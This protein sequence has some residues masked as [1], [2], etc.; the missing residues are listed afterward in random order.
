[1]DDLARPTDPTRSHARPAQC[2]ANP[3][4]GYYAAAPMRFI[5]R[6]ACAGAQHPPRGVGN[7]RAFSSSATALHDVL[8]AARMSAITGARS[9][10][11]RF[12]LAVLAAFPAAEPRAAA[13]GVRLAGLP[14]GWPRALRA[15]RASLVRLLMASRSF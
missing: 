13:A 3:M 1:L 6:N 4:W 9:A 5:N 14:S 10:A 8:P 11:R 15:A 7:P 12:A 2:Y